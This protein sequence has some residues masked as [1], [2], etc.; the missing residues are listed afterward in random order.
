M[1][2]FKVILMTITMAMLPLRASN[3]ADINGDHSVDGVDQAILSNLLSGNL[4]LADYDLSNIVVVA[5][6][7]GDFT[8]I[9]SAMSW[10]D[11]Q[12]PSETNRFLVYVEGN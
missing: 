6:Q 12:N 1:R 2:L 9:S 5:G 3:R 11:R 4:D 10:V 8:T 7:G